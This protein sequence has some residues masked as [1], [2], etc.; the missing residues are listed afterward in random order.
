MD[1]YEVNAACYTWTGLTWHQAL[2][3]LVAELNSD[4][5]GYIVITHEQTGAI[6]LQS[7]HD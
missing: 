4:E 1:S 2:C 3:R 6:V 5:R 7:V